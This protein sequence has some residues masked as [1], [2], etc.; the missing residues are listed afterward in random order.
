MK[1]V[2]AYKFEY[3][4]RDAASYL[5]FGAS[6]Q[7]NGDDTQGS[8]YVLLP[9]GRLQ[10]VRYSV[11]GDSG[12]VADVSYASAGPAFGAA[13]SSL[14]SAAAGQQSSSATRREYSYVQQAAPVRISQQQQAAGSPSYKVAAYRAPPTNYQNNNRYVAAVPRK[15]NQAKIQQLNDE[16]VSTVRRPILMNIPHSCTVNKC[17]TNIH[18]LIGQTNPQ[19]YILQLK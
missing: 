19:D 4:V 9:D 3:T 11:L 13:S 8:Y 16:E 18:K 5:N 17:A 7:R 10:T 1:A 6:E 12:Y 2:P 15:Y 14:S